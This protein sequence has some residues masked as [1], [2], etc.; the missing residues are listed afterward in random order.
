MWPLDPKQWPRLRP[1]DAREG[2]RHRLAATPRRGALAPRPR[3]EGAR[4]KTLEFRTMESWSRLVARLEPL[5]PD[6]RSSQFSRVARNEPA[7]VLNLVPPL[8][9]KEKGMLAAA[10]ET[11]RG[12][13]SEEQGGVLHAASCHFRHPLR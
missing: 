6:G 13:R 12:A 10:M 7:R 5:N 4:P 11:G 3:P 8:V 2:I 9:G 1:H